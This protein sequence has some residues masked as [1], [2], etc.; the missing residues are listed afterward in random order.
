M[1]KNILVLFC[2]TDFKGCFSNVGAIKRYLKEADR[3]SDTEQIKVTTT[4][5]YTF[6]VSVKDKDPHGLHYSL[7]YYFYKTQIDPNS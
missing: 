4:G 7:D 5:K 2:E 1:K 6:T 3:N